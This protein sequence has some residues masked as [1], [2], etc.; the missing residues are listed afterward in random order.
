MGQLLVKLD[1]ATVVFLLAAVRG[2]LFRDGRQERASTERLSDDVQ[3]DADA[4]RLFVDRRGKRADVVY[5]LA[6]VVYLLVAVVETLSEN[7]GRKG[8]S[9]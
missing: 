6:A 1:D 2:K 8:D 3:L 9:R 5:L 7:G 4:L